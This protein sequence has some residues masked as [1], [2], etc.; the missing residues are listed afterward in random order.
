MNEI[1]IL[2]IDD[3]SLF[4][5]G[6]RSIMQIHDEFKIVGEAENGLEGIKRAKQ[7]KPDL[8]LLDLHM[9]GMNG[10]EVLRILTEDMPEVQVLMLTVSEDAEDLLQALQNGARGYLLKNIDIDFLLDAIKRAMRGE[11]VMSDQMAAKLVDAIRTPSPKATT[12]SPEK[13]RLTP[14]ERQIIGLLAQGE[15]N[16]S[17]ARLLDLSESTVKIH[18]QGILRKLQLN[19]RVQ[20]AVYAVEHGLLPHTATD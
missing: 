1:R 17:I 13:A 16:K 2:L 11:S 7:L 12:V 14:R 3:H 6:L 4:R 18:V 5:S 20:A 15:S 19:S 10:L 8:V 9:P